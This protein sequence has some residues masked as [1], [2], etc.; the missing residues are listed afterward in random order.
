[1][2][3][4]DDDS[5]EEEEKDDDVIAVAVVV[6]YLLLLLF[7]Y[8]NTNFHSRFTIESAKQRPTTK[9]RCLVRLRVKVWN[10]L[11]SGT[12]SAQQVKT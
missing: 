10:L 1:M 3:D 8:L 12:Q 9:I 11:K 7:T 5:E 4:D 6:C 2:D